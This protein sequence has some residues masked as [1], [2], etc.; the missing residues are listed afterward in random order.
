MSHDSHRF[1][2]LDTRQPALARS[3][4]NLGSWRGRCGIVT[5]PTHMAFKKRHHR[6]QIPFA[7][8]ETTQRTCKSYNFPIGKLLMRCTRSHPRRVSANND[9]HGVTEVD[10]VFIPAWFISNSM[11]RAHI[12]YPHSPTHLLPGPVYSLQ[13]I[14]INQDPELRDALGRCDVPKLQDLFSTGRARPS[15]M[16]LDHGSEYAVTLLDARLIIFSCRYRLISSIR[17]HY[18]RLRG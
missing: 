1:T 8:I 6:T 9:E 11:I 4:P 3:D 7:P 18:R 14:S 5:T 17:Q 16:I 12:E 15:D 2:G 10:V 13:T